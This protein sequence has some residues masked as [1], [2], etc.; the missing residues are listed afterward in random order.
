MVLSG[1]PPL[2]FFRSASLGTPHQELPRLYSSVRVWRRVGQGEGVEE[3][4]HILLLT[5]HLL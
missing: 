1:A 5:C 2:R 3:G 4:E